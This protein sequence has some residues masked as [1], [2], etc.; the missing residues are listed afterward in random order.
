MREAHT[1]E[2]MSVITVIIIILNWEE[3]ISI[4]IPLVF[5][6]QNIA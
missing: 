3:I 1:K 2:F 4:V 6:K 5:Q